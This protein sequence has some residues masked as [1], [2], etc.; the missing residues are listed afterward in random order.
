MAN[1]MG[2]DLTD[3]TVVINASRMSANYKDVTWRV[4]H[5]IGG[6]GTAPDTMGTAL[7]GEHLRDGEK[8][9]WDG[10]DVERMATEDEI[11][12]AKALREQE[13]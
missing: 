10:F 2:I 8:T 7:F 3:K 1:S 13:A 4:F 6:F 5:V 11:A 12:A 9:R